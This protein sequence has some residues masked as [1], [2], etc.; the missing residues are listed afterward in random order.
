MMCLYALDRRS[1]LAFKDLGM[2]LLVEVLN[3]FLTQDQQRLCLVVRFQG[4]RS[5]YERYPSFFHGLWTHYWLV[6]HAEM[7]RYLSLL[8]HW[9]EANTHANTIAFTGGHV[10]RHWPLRTRCSSQQTGHTG[11]H[12]AVS[13]WTREP[14]AR[15]ANA[16]T[17]G[18]LSKR[19][20]GEAK[21]CLR[22]LA[23]R[24]WPYT[25]MKWTRV[26]V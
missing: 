26:W 9:G 6:E 4:S 18:H 16:P 10:G 17:R 13:S 7:R 25:T 2:C 14:R 23:I 22:C 12:S 3:H 21:G 20:C 24:D 8:L 5:C 19:A 1:T 11:L 15:R